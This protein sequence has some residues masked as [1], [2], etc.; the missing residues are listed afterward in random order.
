VYG[1]GGMT[2]DWKRAAALA[3]QHRI[4]LAGGLT[5]DNVA[6]AIGIVKPAG[7]DVVSGVEAKPGKKNLKKLE[8]FIRKARGA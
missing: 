5:P 4:L 6:K 2:A 7:V 1:G 8:A 3:K